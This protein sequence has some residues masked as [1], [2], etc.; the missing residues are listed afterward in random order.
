MIQ[1]GVNAPKGA[2]ALLA[3]LRRVQLS[4]RLIE[5][6]IRDAVVTGEYPESVKHLI[7]R[8]VSNRC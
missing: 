5:P 4:A 2:L 6:L 1:Q 8:V 7:D 3:V